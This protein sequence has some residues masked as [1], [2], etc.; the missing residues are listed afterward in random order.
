M[1]LKMRVMTKFPAL[2]NAATG[3][4]VERVG[5]VYT[6]VNDWLSFIPTTSIA[7]PSSAYILVVSGTVDNQLYQ[8]IALD[9]FQASVAGL[10]QEI[11]AGGA[12]TIGDASAVV[13]VN[14]TV[15]AAITLTLP[16]AAAKVGKV[17]VADWKGDAA[18]NNI[19]VVPSGA[20]TFQGGLTS[21]IISGDGGSAVFDPIP[22]K[23]Y[24]V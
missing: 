24:A 6:I 13:Q 23:G 22:G 9:D 14:Q 3:I 7:D 19:T 12:Q 10:V 20:E 1:S 16:P 15:G 2:F 18:T 4:A 21:W 17:K 11:T 8:L 5:R